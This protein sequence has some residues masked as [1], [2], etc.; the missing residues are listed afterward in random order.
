MYRACLEGD[1]EEV[2]KHLNKSYY[3]WNKCLYNACI[4]A[5]MSIVELI[6]SKGEPFWLDW[7]WALRGA[8]EGGDLRIVELMIKRG[9]PFGLDDWNWG[10]LNACKGRHLPIVELMIRKGEISFSCRFLLEET[11]Q[12]ALLQNGISRKQLS[13]IPNIQSLFTKLDILNQ[14]ITAEI[15]LVL[16]VRDLVPL[17]T[18]YVCV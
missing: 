5:N 3:H 11:T 4:G 9:E 15:L 1:L 18:Q 8:C 6:I 16:P 7:N 10:L 2:K 13:N 17:C 12:L 14:L